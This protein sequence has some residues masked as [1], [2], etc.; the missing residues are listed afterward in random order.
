[1]SAEFG[2]YSLLLALVTAL[3]QGTIPLIGAAT[4]NRL[5]M[6]SAIGGSAVKEYWRR[7]PA[8][9]LTHRSYPAFGANSRVPE[10]YGRNGR[11]RAPREGDQ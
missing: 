7:S 3:F 10:S 5:W 11:S 4:G 2:Q 1:M 9:S 8:W 6:D